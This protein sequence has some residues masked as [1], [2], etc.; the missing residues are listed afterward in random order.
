MKQTP[1]EK[2][3]QE[4]LKAGVVTLDGF[5]GNDKRHYHDIIA[6]DHI[7]LLNLGKTKEEIADRMQELTDIA[8]QFGDEEGVVEG[9][10]KI[11]Y[12]TERGKL[13]SP[14]M[15]RKLYRKGIIRLTNLTNDISVAWT[16]LNIDMIRN[17]GF[18]EGKGAKHRIEPE[19]L[20]KAIF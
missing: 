1:T 4:R 5:L 14:F 6:E 18:F 13:V 17:Y 8:F 11:Q 7:T 19:L 15:D 10:F 2:L 12:Q 16:P 3:I 20:V 9:N